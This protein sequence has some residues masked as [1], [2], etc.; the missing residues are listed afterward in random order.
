MFAA[1]D[2][3]PDIFVNGSYEEPFAKSIDLSNKIE[4]AF[5]IDLCQMAREN[6]NLDQI[7]EMK[8]MFG[9]LKRQ[10][11]G[12]SMLFNRIMRR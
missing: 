9:K 5:F 6:G 4:R 1:V 3:R 8:A 7:P 11:S 12:L 10:H 2:E